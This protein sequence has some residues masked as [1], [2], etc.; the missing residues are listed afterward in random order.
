M[1]IF[2]C[3]QIVWITLG[4]LSN[5][6]HNSMRKQNLGRG[7][8][9]NHIYRKQDNELSGQTIDHHLKAHNRHSVGCETSFDMYLY[10]PL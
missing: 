5:T 4:T 2:R 7:I 9:D 10:R 6:R 8:Q 3:C 1:K